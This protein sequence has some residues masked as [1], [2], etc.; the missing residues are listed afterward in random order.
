[1][2]EMSDFTLGLIVMPFFLVFIFALGY[3]IYRVKS[4]V[5]AREWTPLRPLLD[6]GGTI[7]GDG[8]GG[9]T[10]YLTGTYRGR[11][12]RASMSPDI[13]K[14]SGESG[15]YANFFTVAL[16]DVPGADNFKITAA[17]SLPRFWHSE[18]RVDTTNGAVREALEAAHAVERVSAFGDVEVSY[19]RSARRLQF[20]EDV[21]PLKV[22]PRERFQQ[23]LDL[24][25]DLAELTEPINRTPATV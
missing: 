17:P 15:H 24:L 7:S 2:S 1:M 14:Y 18:W 3:V 13:S 25:I 9:A 11:R 22:A 6:G 4:A 23:E 19:D 5:M 12:V 8:G 21:R 20:V 10:S 16:L